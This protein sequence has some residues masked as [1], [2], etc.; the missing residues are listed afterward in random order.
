MTT[1]GGSYRAFFIS[2]IGER[3]SSERKRSD[4]VFDHIVTP[5]AKEYKLSVIR[6]DRDPTPGQITTQIVR[7]LVE[8]MVVFADLTGRNPNVYYELGVA[9]SFRL[10]VV[11]LVDNPASLSFDAQNERVIAIGDSGV[12]SV[13]QAEEAKSAL[14]GVLEV[15]LQEEYEPENLITAVAVSQSLDALAPANPIASELSAI[16]ELVERTNLT[17]ARM[18]QSEDNTEDFDV[19][20]DCVELM[21][22]RKKLQS[23]DIV[24][25][26]NPFANTSNTFDQWLEGLKDLAPKPSPPQ[27][28]DEPPF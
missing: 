17:V 24:N 21:V 15:V 1:S 14:R 26:I 18:T 2:Q 16:R 11:I 7:S 27:F 13:S 6:G 25:G 23:D 28:I 5:V 3:G 4:E 19:L 22:R 20:R 12:I 9:H 8:S 10:P